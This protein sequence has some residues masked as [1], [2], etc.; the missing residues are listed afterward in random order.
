MNKG[1]LSEYFE[2]VA[3]K[4]LSAV[5]ADQKKSNQ[6]EVGTTREMRR[7]LGENHQQRFDVNYIWLGDEQEGIPCPDTA[8]HYD[9]R[10]NQP[11]RRP[12][13]RLYY[14][15]NVIT[16]I[17]QE[18]DTLFL[19]KRPGNELLFIVVPA[20]S[21]IE[22]QL[23]WLFGFDIQPNLKFAAQQY[24]GEND[25]TLDFAARFILDELGIEFED[26]NANSID[27]IIERFGLVF[28]KT[29]EFSDLA[30]LTLPRVDARDDADQS[31]LAWLNHEEAMFRQ[32]EKKI[33]SERLKTGFVFDNAVDV[34]GFLSF[35]L[36]VQNRRKSRMGLSFENHL[37]AVFRQH[38]IRFER[39]CATERGNKPDF[40]FPAGKQ[41]HDPSFPN[42]ALTMLAAKSTCKDRWRQVL[43]EADRLTQKHLITLE[44]AISSAQT[45]QMAESSLQLVVPLAIQSSYADIQRDWLLSL[46]DFLN[47]VARRQLA[48]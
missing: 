2:G 43:P 3:V 46:S 19:A 40:L 22:N 11:D 35:S 29:V 16:E 41:Y 48:H 44:P 5:D 9:T 18:G 45:M 26:P 30:R 8:T 14:S 28:P 4:R 10:L 25:A 36:S 42:E 33:V 27:A 21:T 37:S 24:V 32:L 39:G 15:S 13:W 12:E 47:L 17:M 1:L 31:L 34:D 23:L 20:G 7:F 6:H 38:D